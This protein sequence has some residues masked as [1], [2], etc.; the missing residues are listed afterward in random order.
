MAWSKFVP[1][2]LCKS[3]GTLLAIGASEVAFAPFGELGPLDVQVT[4]QDDIGKLESG[5][6]I[7]EAFNAIEGRAKDTYHQLIAEIFQ[8]SGGVVSTQTA[9]HAASEMVGAMYGPIFRQ[10]DPEEVGSRS[11]AMRIGEDYAKRLN[12][13]WSNLKSPESV[14]ILSSFY[15]SHGFVIDYTEACELFKNVR[16]AN[17]SERNLVEH[18]GLTA[19]FPARQ[20]EIRHIDKNEFSQ[21]GTQSN[22]PRTK[23]DESDFQT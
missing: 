17:E 16:K 23:A 6:N 22:A 4:K 5:L 21:E 9:L 8:A 13:K 3:A 12:E 20:P 18:L 10:I 14:R 15:P 2:I 7:S 11:R 1:Q 19:R